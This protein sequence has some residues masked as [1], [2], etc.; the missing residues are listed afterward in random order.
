MEIPTRDLTP[1]STT[2]LIFFKKPNRIGSLPTLALQ[3]LVTAM[4]LT[5]HESGL[6]L[7]K[8]NA[9]TT[10]QGGQQ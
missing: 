2:K 9:P 8:G 1:R 3:A 7:K 4:L 5:G 10:P 6:L